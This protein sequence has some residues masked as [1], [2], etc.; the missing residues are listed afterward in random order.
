M[1]PVTPSIDLIMGPMTAGKTYELLRR[2]RA[3]RKSGRRVLLVNSSCDTEAGSFS[4]ARL[5]G[6]GIVLTHGDDHE[7]AHTVTR[8]ADVDATDYDVVAIDEAQ[9]FEDLADGCERLAREGRVVIVA[10]LSGTFERKPFG[11]VNDLASRA[12]NVD[13]IYGKCPCGAP[14]P[15]TMRTPEGAAHA[16]GRVSVPGSTRDYRAVCRACHTIPA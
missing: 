11:G 5:D 1:K 9:W 16:G 6:S 12:D 4:A 14:A 2:A 8:L 10:G 3:Y 7:P 13:M 15:F